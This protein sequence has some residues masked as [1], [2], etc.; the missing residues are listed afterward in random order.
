MSWYH[1]GL[2]SFFEVVL[3]RSPRR[4]FRRNINL[5][6]LLT[7]ISF[8]SV[9]WRARDLHL[10]WKS[11]QTTFL[12]GSIF[13]NLENEQAKKMGTNRNANRQWGKYPLICIFMAASPK[14]PYQRAGFPSFCNLNFG[15]DGTELDGVLFLFGPSPPREWLREY[16]LHPESDGPSRR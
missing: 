1:H 6:Q 10:K 11:K 3:F 16:S 15:D 2:V 8:I 4:S 13:T 9:S 7:F 14:L 5:S 12:V